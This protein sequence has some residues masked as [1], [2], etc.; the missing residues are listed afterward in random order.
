MRKRDDVKPRVINRN[1][2]GEI[3][4]PKT[5]VVPYEGNEHIYARLAE[6]RRS[7]DAKKNERSV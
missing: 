2:Y 3:F 1:K 5:Y 6:I 7:I 4:D